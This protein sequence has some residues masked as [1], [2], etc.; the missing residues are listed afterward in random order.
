MRFTVTG[1]GLQSKRQ[2]RG[3]SRTDLAHLSGIPAAR[4]WEIEAEHAPISQPDRT[5]LLR[6]L[7]AEWQ[8]LFLATSAPQPS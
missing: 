8:E 7:D 6:A 4:L 5:A 1:E 2:Q 3:L